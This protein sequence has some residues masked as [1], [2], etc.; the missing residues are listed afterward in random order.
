MDND[1]DRNLMYQI[2]LLQAFGMCNFDENEISKKTT[3]LYNQ[4]KDCSQ[5]K[6]IIQEGIVMN[7]QMN[8][9]DVVM[10][11]CLFSYQFFD[12]FHKCLIDYFTTGYILEESKHNMIERIKND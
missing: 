1:D 6:E 9:S 4:L 8:L 3:E 12:L 10:F 11:M 7:S 2:Q 5:I